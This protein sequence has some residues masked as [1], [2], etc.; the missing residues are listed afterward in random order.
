[1]LPLLSTYFLV[2]LSGLLF[3][4]VLVL[5]GRSWKHKHARCQRELVR[6]RVAKERMVEFSLCW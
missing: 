6:E 2:C 4:G 1:L 5:W 3:A